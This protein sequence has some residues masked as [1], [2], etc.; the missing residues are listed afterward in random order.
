MV[1]PMPYAGAGSMLLRLPVHDQSKAPRVYGAAKCIFKKI[2]QIGQKIT[3]FLLT[4]Q[5]FSET[6]TYAQTSCIAAND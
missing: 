5:E 4:M 2:S 3:E 6:D 1:A